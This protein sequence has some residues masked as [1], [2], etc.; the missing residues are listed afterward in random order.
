MLLA[1]MAAGRVVSM[2]L[3]G[4]ATLGNAAWLLASVAL[5]LVLIS[6][7]F[8]TLP[9]RAERKAQGAAAKAKRDAADARAALELRRSE[10][11]PA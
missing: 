9:S 5:A 2:L 7:G 11:P 10:D 6:A 4:A 8:E 1:G 3:D